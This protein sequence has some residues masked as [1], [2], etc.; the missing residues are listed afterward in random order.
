MA[1]SLRDRR[2]PAVRAAVRARRCTRVRQRIRPSPSTTNWAPR[3]RQGH[4]VGLGHR[5]LAIIA[6]APP[7]PEDATED[8]R[9]GAGDISARRLA[10]Y[11]RAI[12]AA[13]LEL[14]DDAIAC[15]PSELEHGARALREL[16]ARGTRFTALLAMS[17]V[18]AIGALRAARDLGWRVPED[19]SIVGFDDIE[20]ASYVDP[21]LTTVH[22]SPRDKGETA[23][24]LLF[25]RLDRSSDGRPEHRHVETQPQGAWLDGASAARAAGGGPGRVSRGDGPPAHVG[26]SVV[27][28][29]RDPRGREA[30][31]RWDRP[32]QASGRR[33][34]R[35]VRDPEAFQ[36]RPVDDGGHRHL[37]LRRQRRD[38]RAIDQC[39][40]Q[41]TSAASSSSAAPSGSAA[42]SAG[43]GADLLIWA[44]D[45]RAAALKPLADAVRR[46]ATASRSRSRRSP[47]TSSRTS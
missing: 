25:G 8:G 36:L 4:L 2:D 29:P 17:D 30:P 32:H 12:R 13:G 43:T 22:Q 9:P 23:L 41:S 27:E 26:W 3:R 1:R 11:R 46:G 44:D 6:F 18:L 24:R 47:R 31:W 34:W 14:S 45:K 37:G 16:V 10:G 28:L 42:G 40:D 15:G 7:R 35:S 33:A 20:L 39:R 38:D 21:P 5:E 19:L